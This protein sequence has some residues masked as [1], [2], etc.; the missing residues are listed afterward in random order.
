ML[1][2]DT[3]K[4]RRHAGLVSGVLLALALF[5]TFLALTQIDRDQHASPASQ[6]SIQPE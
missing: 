2:I 4:S 1:H 3:P 5:G 6:L